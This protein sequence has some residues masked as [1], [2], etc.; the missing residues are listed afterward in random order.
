MSEAVSHS[1]RG[2]PNSKVLR[3]LPKLA[4]ALKTVGPFSM[5]F[6]VGFLASGGAGHDDD[7]LDSGGSYAFSGS[8]EEYQEK[9][10]ECVLSPKLSSTVQ[11]RSALKKQWK[12]RKRKK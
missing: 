3:T 10:S 4:E 2:V 12:I 1:W 8:K 6:F 9:V 11:Q 7:I 5:K